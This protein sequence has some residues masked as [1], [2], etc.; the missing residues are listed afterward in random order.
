MTADLTGEIR[1]R[2]GIITLDRPKALNAINLDM[3]QALDALLADWAVNPAIDAVLIR[4]SG[5]RAFCAGGD[6]RS[7]GSLPDSD[8][9]AEL[10]RAFFGAEYRAN[11]RIGSF[12]KPYIALMAGVTMGGGLGISVL[13][14]HRIVGETLR[15]AMPETVLGLFP[16]VGASWFLNR[17]PGMI[18]R[19]LALTGAPLDAAD[20]LAAGLATHHVPVDRFAALTEALAGA[21]SLDAG[22]VD[23]I[24]GE[25][26]VDLGGSALASRRD[27]IDRLFV[28]DDLD[29]V[30]DRV[31]FEAGAEPWIED[32]R[33]TFRRASPTS[34]RATWRR[35]LDG[36]GQ[37][38]KD[39]LIDDYRMAVR[40]VAGHDFAEGVR[41]ILID[42]DQ[43]PV[44]S[45]ARLDAVTGEDIDGML[46]PLEIATDSMGR[47]DGDLTMEDHQSP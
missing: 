13:G 39:V 40:M 22:I 7:I 37:S 46:R 18:G 26:E 10:G 31:T 20:A 14:S 35:M 8:Q 25:H 47:R 36:A 43:S 9:R 38:L 21:S 11:H 17:C 27:A 19:Y 12:P 41:A 34:L 15:M 28:G 29:A 45:P 44:W 23:A 33:A 3:A 16:D 1:G 32:A 4:S 5:E 2:L 30:I 24:L 6:V 42:K